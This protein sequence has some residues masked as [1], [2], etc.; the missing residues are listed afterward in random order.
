ME[1]KT[2]REAIGKGKG[3]INALSIDRNILKRYMN[4]G[5]HIIVNGEW[6]FKERDYSLDKKVVV[7]YRRNVLGCIFIIKGNKY[8]SFIHLNKSNSYNT[9][10]IDNQEAIKFINDN[11]NEVM[12]EAEHLQKIE[13]IE[14][15]SQLK[16]GESIWKKN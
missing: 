16:S 11:I 13:A 9:F 3:N 1:L 15:I 12:I 10:R 5:E 14:M 6:K 2:I 7:A 8:F 4:F